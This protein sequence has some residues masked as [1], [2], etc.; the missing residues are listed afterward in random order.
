MNVAVVGAGKMGAEIFRLLTRCPLDVT[1]YARR[2]ESAREHARKHLKDLRRS[3]RRGTMTEADAAARQVAVRVTD[4][5]ADLASADLVIEAIAEDLEQKS[6]L[7]RD[8]ENVIRPDTALL[9]NTSSLSIEALAAGLRRPERFCGLHFF[10][11]VLL[12][13]LAEIITWNGVSDALVETVMD[14]CRRISKIPMRVV[15]GP[16]SIVNSVLANYYTEAFYILE[17]GQALPSKIDALAARF[18]SFGP[19]ES[20]DVVGLDLFITGLQN[21][22]E[23]G[24]FFQT[25]PPDSASRALTTEECAGRSGFYVPYLFPV[26]MQARRFGRKTSAGLYL[27]EGDQPI[28]DDLSFYADPSRPLAQEDR[29]TDELLAKRLLY[30]VFNGVLYCLHASSASKEDLDLGMKEVLLMQKGPFGLMRQL[31][32]EQVRADFDL[33]AET[34][35]ER[36]RHENG[37]V[38]WQ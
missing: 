36:F 20:A 2:T 17:D 37:W 33:L 31:G 13:A 23:M 8:L 28:D 19:C 15:D 29:Q 5:L 38:T 6:A 34:V 3:V 24:A 16:G 9:T 27:Y 11:P 32:V 14:F 1:L 22:T 30:A 25:K 4:R 10:H 7:F 35:G 12:I 26:L 18:C 21:A